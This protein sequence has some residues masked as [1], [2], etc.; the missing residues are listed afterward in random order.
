ML[1]KLVGLRGKLV[2]GL[3]TLLALG[4]MVAG[5]YTAGRYDQKA[6]C[7]TKE[8]T[9]ELKGVQRHDEIERGIMGMDVPALDNGLSGW[10]RHE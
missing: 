8:L 10:L 9:N 1:S 2:M 7:D 3:L 6:H 5:A 4:A